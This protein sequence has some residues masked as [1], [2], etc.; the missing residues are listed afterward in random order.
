MSRSVFLSPSEL[1]CWP[2][3]NSDKTLC[4]CLCFQYLNTVIPYEKKG[5]PPSVEDLQMLTK[6]KY[7][8]RILSQE[9]GNMKWNESMDLTPIYF[10]HPVLFAM[11]EDSEKVPTL[12]TDYILKGKHYRE[13]LSK[14]CSQGYE[15]SLYLF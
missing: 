3:T 11:K 5:T 8:S 7:P 10:F 14:A 1:K 9:H 15:Q 2:E 4:M 13:D 6:S 12:L